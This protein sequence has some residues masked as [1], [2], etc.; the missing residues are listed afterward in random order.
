VQRRIRIAVASLAVAAGLIAAAAVPASASDGT[1]DRMW[2]WG[3]DDGTAAFQICTSGC[4]A[5]IPGSGDGQ[6]DSI[7]GVSTDAAGSVYTVEF[8]NQRV[9]KFSSSGNFITK[10][11]TPGS[12]N[13]QFSAPTALATDSAGNVYVADD[14]NSRIQKFDS[15]GNFLTKWGSFGEGE[16][17]FHIF[18]GLGTDSGGNVYVADEENQR[19]QKF[20]STGNFI[21][22]WGWGV[23]DGTAA[24]QICTSGCQAGIPGN[25][26]GQFDSPFDAATDSAGNVYIADISNS[27]IQKFDSTGNFLTQWASPGPIRVATDSAGNVYVAELNDRIQKFTSAGSL[28]TQW[29]SEGTAEGQFSQP[30]G[31]GTDSAANVY[32]GDAGNFVLGL[33][34]TRIQKFGTAKAAPETPA[35][36]APAAS[37]DP[38]CK[39]LR[40]KHKRQNT[41][42]A[43]AG[44]EPKHSLIAG[45]IRD[46]KRRLK[47]LRCK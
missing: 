9:Q 35:N 32:V 43:K 41:S 14:G 40:R 47:K 8:D 5:G 34:G 38:K 45:N 7:R 6:F 15:T 17:Q 4:Q 18:E 11:G 23:D 24:F 22:M 28:I 2:G 30:G 33:S 26:D 27:R 37:E 3:V 46:T 31:L 29:G 25:G 44:S 20:D 39:K 13:G 36:P 19:I 16:G 1:F 12:G 10:W 42:L 21:L